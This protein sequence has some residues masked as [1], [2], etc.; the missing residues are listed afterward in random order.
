MNALT[1]SLATDLAWF[2][3]LAIAAVWVWVL[4][5]KWFRH[6]RGRAAT[7]MADPMPRRGCQIGG[8]G[9]PPVAIFDRHPAGAI[10]V[11][12]GHEAAVQ[13]WVGPYGR[14]VPFDQDTDVSAFEREWGQS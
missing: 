7:T 1:Q 11:C 3:I 14:D 8:C 6:C 4:A 9:K 10:Y 5:T 13:G 2:L 12:A